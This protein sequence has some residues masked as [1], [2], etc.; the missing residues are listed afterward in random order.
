MDHIINNVTYK[1]EKLN[2]NKQIKVTRKV[3]PLFSLIYPE[4]EGKLKENPDQKIEWS[5]LLPKIATYIAEMSDDDCNS[6]IYPC[7]SVVKRE[8]AEGNFVPVSKNTEILF[9]DMDIL[10][11]IQLVMQVITESLSSFFAPEEQ[12]K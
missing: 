5:G 1:I 2:V 12:K 3:L 6:I 7:L 8:D 10:I 11:V 4:I 9:D